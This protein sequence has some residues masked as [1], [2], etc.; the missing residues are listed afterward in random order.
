MSMEQLL[1]WELAEGTEIPGENL[2]QCHFVH[3]KPNA[4][5]PRMEP[6]PQR[7][8]TGGT[9]CLWLALQLI[10]R[11]VSLACAAEEALLK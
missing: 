9:Q 11:Y 7:R 4:M 3:H 8:E 2:P 10:R 6:W 5:W 1:D